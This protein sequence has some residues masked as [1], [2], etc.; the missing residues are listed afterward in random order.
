MMPD[1]PPRHRPTFSEAL[2]TSILDAAVDAVITID[3]DGA[4][5]TWSA[6][7][8]RMFGWS[9][10]EVVGRI[11]ATTI[12]PERYR[13]QHERG[14]ARMRAGGKPAIL[15]QRIEI[16]ALHRDGHEL[17]VELTVTRVPLRDTWLFSAFVRDLT[18]QK[19]SAE[20]HRRTAEFLSAAQA[21]ANVG[22]WEWDIVTNAITWSEEAYRLFDRSPAAGPI[23]FDSYLALIH[24]DDRES[25]AAAI[26]QAL[27]SAGS[28]EVDHRV[29]RAD[30]SIRYLY[31]RGGVVSDASGKPTRM[32]GT[33]LDISARRQAEDDLRRANDYLRTVIEA[34]P[35]AIYTL[36]P[37]G[38]VQSWNPAAERLY[39]WTAQEAIGRFLP[40]VP[41]DGLLEFM[42]LR[43]RV[44]AGEQITGIELVRRKK[45]GS[46]ATVNLFAAPLHDASGAVTGI[47]AVIEDVT[48][49]KQLERQFFQAQKMEAVGRLAGGVAHDFNNLLTVIL[50]GCDLIL[51]DE[52]SDL[53][54]ADLQEIRKAA[55][56]AA[57]LTGQLLAV[58]RQQV[59]APQIVD[60]NVLVERVESLLRR[61]LG[62]DI[63]LLRVA[64]AELGTIAADPSQLEQ[65]I[66]TLAV[67]ARDAMPNGGK[68]THRN[69][70]R[71]ARRC[72]RAVAPP[73]RARV[74]RDD[75]GA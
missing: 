41:E 60:L 64:G 75:R 47:L 18:E 57:S 70:K 49:V 63:E 22:S 11:L 66:M 17:P 21:V 9:A 54:R 33:V 39:G 26:N 53:K 12:I 59:L 46:W 44:L 62:E 40:V 48:A 71:G 45:D 72:V 56:R 6:Q 16:T 13:Q 19:R 10:S 51:M 30:G 58:S 37:G 42:A 31:G 28:F 55:T 36:D 8:E 2:L 34:A 3:A 24:P 32:V 1:D 73:D 69:R 15:N 23:A 35:L 38:F 50:G 27:V 5:L 65:V 14:L 29:V 43:R 52:V 4:V 20:E 61:L 74:L 67:N 68:L 25:V 7:A